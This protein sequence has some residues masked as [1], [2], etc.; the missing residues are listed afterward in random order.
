MRLQTRGTGKMARDIA[1]ALA[2]QALSYLAR[3]PE[4]LGSFLAT[5]GIGPESIRAA[6]ATP[7]FL[8][9]VLDY[10]IANETLLLE[11]AAEQNLDPAL[12]VRARDVL[13]GARRH[14]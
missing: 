5:T 14:E 12:I 1:E 13:P 7:G 10:V 2:V 8:E 6:A 4:R 9:G 3:E 11:F